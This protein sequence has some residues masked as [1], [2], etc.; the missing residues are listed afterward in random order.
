[1][2]SKTLEAEICWA[3]HSLFSGQS[4]NSN[5]DSKNFF[6]SNFHDCSI[7]KTFAMCCDKLRYV[8]NDGLVPYFKV[9]I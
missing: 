6:Q 3:P 2:S 1:M 9:P 7:V 8:I 5:N 4:D